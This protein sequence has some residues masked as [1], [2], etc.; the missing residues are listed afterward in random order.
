MVYIR[1]TLVLDYTTT[2]IMQN[3]LLLIIFVFFRFTSD[4]IHIATVACGKKR[5]NE[6]VTLLKSIVYFNPSPF[7]LHIF[8]DLHDNKHLLNTMVSC[9]CL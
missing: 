6:A 9:I 2:A 4:V 5:M 3:M 7:H 1:R 8:T